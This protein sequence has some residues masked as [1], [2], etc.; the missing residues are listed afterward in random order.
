MDE[1]ESGK[2]RLEESVYLAMIVFGG[3]IGGYICEGLEKMREQQEFYVD[4]LSVLP[5]FYVGGRFL[6]YSGI[7]RQMGRGESLLLAGSGML[8]M[9]V[10]QLLR[11][12]EN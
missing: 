1:Q 12:Y 10:R 7:D 8:G 2:E 9:S 3:F 6:Y 5:F 11:L 4:L